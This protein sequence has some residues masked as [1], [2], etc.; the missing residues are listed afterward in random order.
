M[1]IQSANY[2][3][4]ACFC[5]SL[6]LD[7]ARK[8]CMRGNALIGWRWVVACAVTITVTGGG[9]QAAEPAPASPSSQLAKEGPLRFLRTA[10]QVHLLTREEA[11]R[12][13]QAVIRGVVSCSLPYSEAVVIQDSIWER[14][15]PDVGGVVVPLFDQTTQRF[16]PVRLTPREAARRREENEARADALLDHLRSL[17]LGPVLVTS[18]DR[19]KIFQAFLEWTDERIVSRGHWW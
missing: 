11:A 17:D 18:S 6:L 15:F 1:L 4:Q 7:L 13:Y 5:V 10:E 3:F 9:N 8:M 19:G 2:R 12:G 14:S 16:A